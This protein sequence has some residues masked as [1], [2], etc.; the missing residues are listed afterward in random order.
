MFSERLK[1]AIDDLWMMVDDLGWVQRTH[2]PWPGSPTERRT[3][4]GSH[5][6]PAESSPLTV[7]FSILFARGQQAVDVVINTYTPRGRKKEPINF[8]L[9][10]SSLILDRNR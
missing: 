4:W 7:I 6:G 3:V 1:T 9:C 10:S 2:E 8:L 5:L